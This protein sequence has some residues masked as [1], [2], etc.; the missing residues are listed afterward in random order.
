MCELDGPIPILNRSKTLI[1]IDL[2]VLR[3]VTCEECPGRRGS[4]GMLEMYGPTRTL[5][6]GHPAG[7]VRRVRYVG[8]L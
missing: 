7:V 2:S 4:C 3:N 1:A 8:H 5:R 6:A